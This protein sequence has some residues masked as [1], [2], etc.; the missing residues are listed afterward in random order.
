MSDTRQQ[1]LLNLL[2]QAFS[3]MRRT[4]ELLREL[5]VLPPEPRPALRVVEEGGDDA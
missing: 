2:E 5:G 3:D 4:E 1:E